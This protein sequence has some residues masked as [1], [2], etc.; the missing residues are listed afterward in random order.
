[1][2]LRSEVYLKRQRDFLAGVISKLETYYDTKQLSE[3]FSQPLIDLPKY[4][5]TRLCEIME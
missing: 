1:M 5:S 2:N 4:S 3:L